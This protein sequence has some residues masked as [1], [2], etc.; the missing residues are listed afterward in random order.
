MICQPLG[1]T[2]DERKFKVKKKKFIF[3]E[4]EK[5]EYEWKQHL[6]LRFVSR[7]H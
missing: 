6:T 1:L 7:D 4:R 3:E 5:F 2:T